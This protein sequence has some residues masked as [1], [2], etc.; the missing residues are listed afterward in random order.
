MRAIIVA[1]LRQDDTA[2]A[3]TARVTVEI[4]DY[5]RIIP[6]AIQVASRRF[7]Y[8]GAASLV[9]VESVETFRS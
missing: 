8:P 6:P 1:T 5:S 4:P 7:G 3:Y 9:T 2:D